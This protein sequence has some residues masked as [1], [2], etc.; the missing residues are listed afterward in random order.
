GKIARQRE[1]CFIVETSCFGFPSLP[2]LL[3]T[4]QRC[5][6]S[7]AAASQHGVCALLKPFSLIKEGADVEQERDRRREIKPKGLVGRHARRFQITR[8]KLDEVYVRALPCHA[9]LADSRERGESVTGVRSAHDPQFQ[10][11]RCQ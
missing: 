5:A 11:R 7:L 2:S 9:L 1:G 10:R 6:A 3:E 4:C 8:R